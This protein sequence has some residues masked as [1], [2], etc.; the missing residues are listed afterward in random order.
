MSGV[1]QCH[2]VSGLYVFMNMALFNLVSTFSPLSIIQYFLAACPCQ[3]FGFH[4]GS[5]L[6]ACLFR[7]VGERV[8]RGEHRSSYLLGEG[9]HQSDDDAQNR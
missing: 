2:C 5:V 3:A 1:S 6:W 4:N 8:Q 7:A 9:I